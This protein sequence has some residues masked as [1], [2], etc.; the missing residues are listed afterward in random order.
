MADGA[1][2]NTFLGALGWG[3]LV[4]VG[5]VGLLELVLHCAFRKIPQELEAFSICPIGV[6]RPGPG[7]IPCPMPEDPD[8]RCVW[9]EFSSVP[10]QL[11]LHQCAMSSGEVWF[12]RENPWT[13]SLGGQSILCSLGWDGPQHLSF[14]RHFLSEQKS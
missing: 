1:P 2:S 3:Q 13:G 8:E 6:F 4:H 9:D 5:V 7:P 11:S 14:A 10:H 12:P